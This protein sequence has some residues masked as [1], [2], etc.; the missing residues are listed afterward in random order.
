[1][2]NHPAAIGYV[3]MAEMNSQ[4]RTL[5]VEDVAP[6]AAAVRSGAYHLS[7]LIYLY[8]LPGAA[9]GFVDFVLSPAG[10]TVVAQRQVPIR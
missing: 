9:Q 8:R 1:V 5:K 6:T 10:Q 7:R 3:T 4:V 2:A